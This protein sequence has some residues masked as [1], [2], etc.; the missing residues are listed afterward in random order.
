[1]ELELSNVNLSN[2]ILD[3]IETFKH[4]FNAKRIKL[5]A[6]IKEKIYI[7]GDNDKLR[8]IIINLLSNALKFTNE[9]GKVNINLYEDNL[10]SEI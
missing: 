1:M 7:S 4:E 8:Q 5:D 10:I 3:I 2:I 9:N 6:N